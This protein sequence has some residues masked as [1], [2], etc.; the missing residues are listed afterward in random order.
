MVVCLRLYFKRVIYIYE[1]FELWEYESH[2]AVSAA[3]G[4][5]VMVL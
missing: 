5:A 2:D 4:D 1:V 3:V